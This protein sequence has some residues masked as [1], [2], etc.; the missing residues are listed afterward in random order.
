[1]INFASGFT[2]APNCGT[3]A[4]I[5]YTLTSAPALPFTYSFEPSTA[6]FDVAAAATAIGG[7]Y[8]LTI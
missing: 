5:T 3:T 1:M 8:A 2:L 4:D 7:S 6:Q